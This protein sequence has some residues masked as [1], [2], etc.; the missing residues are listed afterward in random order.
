[1]VNLLKYCLYVILVTLFI[2]S[3][4]WY[5][6]S[7]LISWNIISQID[8]MRAKGMNIS[9][10]NYHI[11]GFPDNLITI[12]EKPVYQNSDK[13]FGWTTD[14]LVITPLSL[15]EQTAIIAFP[16]EQ[17][18]A[19]RKTG[20]A[21]KNNIIMRS[22]MLT[23]LTRFQNTVPEPIRLSANTL[24]LS[25]FSGDVT[26]KTGLFSLEAFDDKLLI[27]SQLQDMITLTLKVNDI[28]PSRFWKGILEDNFSE[29]TILAH[30]RN[31][32][33]V[34]DLH[35][36]GFFAMRGFDSPELVIEDAVLKHPLSNIRMSGLLQW[37][38]DMMLNGYLSV[39]VSNYR[40]LVAFL[41]KKGVISEHFAEQL[42][43]I[44]S[45]IVSTKNTQHSTGD[46]YIRLKVKKN[47][48]YRDSVPLFAFPQL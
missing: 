9:L 38:N 47:I 26:L 45:F 36:F 44:F 25:L 33:K 20:E 13:T 23:L 1:M 6:I 37:D 35:R 28:V 29:M 15:E 43:F 2:Y 14:K 34:K 12:L 10:L 18:F 7:Y 27:D 17:Y 48:V 41:V 16:E 21:V 39:T 24:S 3:F 46:A 11:T 8:E 30:L 22:D 5:V 40:K 4:L 42:R 32:G 31:P 19:V